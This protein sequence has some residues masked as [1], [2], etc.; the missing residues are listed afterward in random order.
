MPDLFA[1]DPWLAQIDEQ[2]INPDQVIIDPHH[3]LWDQDNLTYTLEQLHADTGD[4]HNVIKTVFIECGASY[5]PEG[6]DHLKPVGETEFVA[7]NAA[8]S[9]QATGKSIIA[10]I[11]AHAELRHRRLAEVLDEHAIA[12]DTLFK[13]IRDAGAWDPS[14]EALLI[15]PPAPQHLFTDPDFRN[16]VKMLGDRGLTYDS[17]HFHHQNAEFRGLAAAVPDTVMVLDHFGTPLGV[18]AY[19]GKR[20]EIFETWKQDIA[21]IAE[22]PN[23]YAKLG[24]LAM[25]DNGFGW[26]GRDVPPTSDEFV[27]AQARYYHHTIDCFGPDRCMFESNFPVDRV[28][29]GYRVLWNGLKKI[30]SR[31]NKDEQDAMFRRTAEA[32]YNL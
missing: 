12:G 19:E 28:S 24:G 16:G 7:L 20:D 5:R 8:R 13:G 26:F 22:C 3:H 18:G 9:A 10:G 17:W 31:Y 32:V 4:G 2:V 25:P 30:A 23:V 6:P 29:I 21:A 14:P 15:P 27:D 11:V 1:N